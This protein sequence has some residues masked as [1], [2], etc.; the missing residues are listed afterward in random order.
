[1]PSELEVPTCNSRGVSQASAT[2]GREGHAPACPRSSGSSTLPAAP[3]IAALALLAMFALPVAAQSDVDTSRRNAIVRAIE[4]AAPAVVTINVVEVHAHRSLPR[5]FEDFW[6][7]FEPPRPRLQVQ[8]HRIDSAGSG[9]IF[10]DR[11]HV[12]TNFH[13]I[14]DANAIDSVTLADGRRVPAEYVG[15]DERT[16]LAVLRIKEADAPYLRMGDSDGL[17]T[18]EWVI[19]IGNPFGALMEDAQ[20]TVSVGVVSANHRRLNQ[21]IG[22][23][24]RLYQDMIQT[25]AAINPGNSGGP[26]TNAAGEVVGV[27]TMI[28]S[29]SG[30]SVGLG[31]AIPINRVRRITEEIIEFGRRRDPWTGFKVENVHEMSE[32]FRGQYGI[33]ANSGC[34]V[35][36]ILKDSPAYKSGIR[37]GDLVTGI[38]GHTVN[39][40]TDIDFVVWGLFVGDTVSLDISR[41]GKKEKVSFPIKEL[42][43]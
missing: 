24:N 20:P 5:V 10:D 2:L 35:V 8:K 18:G 16:D 38:N 29:K 39:T 28:F 14:E 19:A 15:C 12:L 3:V 36:N 1:M 31:F 41:D 25:D 32:A 7:M 43:K 6:G 4:R 22:G 33:R 13:V 27:N 9:F 30:G 11:G 21:S 34:L 26:L 42:Q 23:G 40:S 17:M 37:P